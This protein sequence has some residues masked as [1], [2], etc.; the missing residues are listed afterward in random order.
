[1]AAAVMGDTVITVR[2]QKEHLILKG[3]SASRPAVTENNRLS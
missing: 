1:M 2:S 3:I